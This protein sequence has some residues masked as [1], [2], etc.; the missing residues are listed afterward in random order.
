ME[1]DQL[2]FAYDAFLPFVQRLMRDH[3]YNSEPVAI[4]MREVFRI[5]CEFSERAVKDI[6][7]AVHLET[8]AEFI[9]ACSDTIPGSVPEHVSQHLYAKVVALSAHLLKDPL[10]E[11][12]V[13]YV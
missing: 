10:K 4:Q 7:E 8:L 3:D 11:K 5:V 6:S 12:F 13:E 9:A 1:D 2:A